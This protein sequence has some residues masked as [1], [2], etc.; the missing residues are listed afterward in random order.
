MR[1]TDVRPPAVAG[2]FYPDSPDR[3]RAQLDALLGHTPAPTGGGGPKAVIVPH[4]GWIYSGPVAASAYATIGPR[5]HEIERVVVLG[6]AHTVALEAMAVPASRTWVTPLGEIEIDAEPVRASLAC[7]RVVAD[8]RPHWR[9]HAIEVQLPFLQH[10]LPGFRLLPVV[11]GWV[12]TH[13]VV[14]LL[15][16]VWGGEET[17]VVISTDLSHYHDHATATRLDQRTAAAIVAADG[18]A[19]GPEDACGAYPLRGLLARAARNGDPIELLDRRT[20]ADT[21]GDPDRVVGYGAFAVGATS[22]SP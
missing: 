11:V 17:L 10:L 6:P 14:G 16:A 3:C 2:T 7:P 22:A 12:P 19:V 15:D 4:A 1:R 13:D 20:S 18:A 21:A 9:E 8:D 5:V